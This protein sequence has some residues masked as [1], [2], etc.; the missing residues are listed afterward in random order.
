MYAKVD[1]LLYF[2]LVLQTYLYFKEI[3]KKKDKMLKV[4]TVR[5]F[6]N[7]FMIHLISLN[8]PHYLNHFS[9]WTS[10]ALWLQCRKWELSCLSVF[11]VLSKSP[12]VASLE[13]CSP[14][15][16]FWH[17]WK[18]AFAVIV[19]SQIFVFI[20]WRKLAHFSS[21]TGIA[22]PGAAKLKGLQLFFPH[23]ICMT[24]RAA[25]GISYKSY[26]FHCHFE[27]SHRHNMSPALQTHIISKVIF[28]LCSV[29]SSGFFLQKNDAKVF[30]EI[31]LVL[32]VTSKSKYSCRVLI[33]NHWLY[34]PTYNLM[35]F[36]YHLV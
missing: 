30:W 2:T 24:Y 21:D 29:I 17:G 4:Q 3:V 13:I 6:F 10:P 1:M 33:F 32:S 15:T 11:G 7:C 8:M 34:V 18:A 27:Q 16:D 19:T 31:F 5:I 28:L 22:L 9:T 26:L 20:R 23:S 35:L 14:F 25:S 36:V 12:C